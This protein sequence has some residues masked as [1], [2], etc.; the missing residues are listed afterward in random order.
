MPSTHVRDALG[1]AE[2][3]HGASDRVL[4]AGE[5]SEVSEV[6]AAELAGANLE[7]RYLGEEVSVRNEA[8]PMMAGLLELTSARRWNDPIHAQVFHDLSVV[9]IGMSHRIDRELERIVLPV[10]WT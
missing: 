3:G 2:V 7:F 6:D 4:R 1:R 5:L 9:V 8:R 10:T